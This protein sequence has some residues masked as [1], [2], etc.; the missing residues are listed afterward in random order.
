V[1][2]EEIGKGGVVAAQQQEPENIVDL[3]DTLKNDP[4]E[5]VGY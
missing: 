3:T 5:Q 2:D 1:Q 4:A